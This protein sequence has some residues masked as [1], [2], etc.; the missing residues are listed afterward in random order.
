MYTS[1]AGKDR[2]R[3]A[4]TLG[5]NKKRPPLD[6]WAKLVG[7]NGS[8]WGLGEPEWSMDSRILHF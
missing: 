5:E 1:A 3:A 8:C 4:S 7:G 6:L 2:D